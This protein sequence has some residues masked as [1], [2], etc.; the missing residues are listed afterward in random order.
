MKRIL[1]GSMIAAALLLTTG[2]GGDDKKVD[3]PGVTADT[4]APTIGATA[5]GAIDTAITLATDDTAVTS[6]TIAGDDAG[7]F[8]KSGATATATTAG[9]YNI[10]VTA[11]DAASN[12]ATQAVVVTVTGGTDPDPVTGIVSGGL[13]WTALAADD[14][15][16]ADDGKI[17]RDEAIAKCPA[18]TTLPTA[19]QLED[20]NLTDLLSADKLNVTILLGVWV[21]DNATSA[22]ALDGAASP[23]DG[24]V[25]TPDA[26]DTN[27][28]TCVKAAN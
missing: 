22:Y 27:Y 10:T 17:L 14:D 16:S 3:A 5:T 8:T 6:M 19:Q 26:G 21:D 25:F 20:S 7:M 11:A 18:G 2:C 4:T 13:V 28:Y 1:L 12:S 23:V 24:Y 9:T 15:D